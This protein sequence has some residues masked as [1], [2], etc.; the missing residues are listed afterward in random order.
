METFSA[1][2]AISAGNSPVTG[3][4]PTQRPVTRGFDVFFDLRPNERLSKQSWGWWL[5]TLSIPLWRHRNA[6]TESL[7]PR[8]MS[9]LLF[10]CTDLVSVEARNTWI[11]HYN[12]PI[13]S[14]P[15]LHVGLFSVPNPSIKTRISKFCKRSAGKTP[16]S[17]YQW[18]AIMFTG[19]GGYC[20][21]NASVVSRS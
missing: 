7:R 21:E 17:L 11:S 13:S 14:T 4:F 16:R 18:V 12:G 8:L 2:L 1:L 3:E 6:L 15:R 9:L 19:K 5:E 10:C 20:T